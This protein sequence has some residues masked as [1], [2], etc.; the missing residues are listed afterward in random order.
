M[1]GKE[2]EG[3]TLRAGN[4]RRALESRIFGEQA[5]IYPM[6]AK[7]LVEWVE[8]SELEELVP[9]IIGSLSFS[10][11][12]VFGPE[13]GEVYDLDDKRT[14]TYLLNLF[15]TTEGATYRPDALYLGTAISNETEGRIRNADRSNR[16]PA[17][18]EKRRRK[19]L[20]RVGLDE[21]LAEEK[22]RIEKEE[23][24]KTL[25]RAA[26]FIEIKNLR[27]AR[28]IIDGAFIQRM[29]TCEDPGQG[30]ELLSRDRRFQPPITPDKGHWQSIFGSYEEAG[31]DTKEFGEKLDKTLRAIVEVALPGEGRDAPIFGERLV[32]GRKE[33]IKDERV[34]GIPAAVY[35]INFEKAEVF[36][37]W[38]KH[39]LEVSGGRLD[40]V[41]A[42]WRIALAWELP[43]YLGKAIKYK[44]RDI[45]DK[46]GEVTGKREVKTTVIALPSVGTAIGPW[47]MQLGDKQRIE[48]G[49]DADGNRRVASKNPSHTGYPLNFLGPQE[50]VKR[51]VGDHRRLE[52]TLANQP[53]ESVEK[54]RGLLKNPVALKKVLTE[55][56]R[57]RN[58]C[59]SF[60]HESK[61]DIPNPRNSQEKIR[62]SLWE[63]WRGN[64]GRK[65]EPMSLADPKF[66]WILTE[67]AR[68]SDVG[69][70]SPGSFGGWLLRRFRAFNVVKNIRSR[71]R[72]SEM[73]APEFFEDITRNW[74]KIFGVVLN[75]PKSEKNYLEPWQNPRSW[76]VAG[77]LYGHYSGRAKDTKLVGKGS[78]LDH[79]TPHTNEVWG[80]E[81]SGAESA[82]KVS[83]D[84][85]FRHARNA[86]F[87]RQE[88]E[89][90]IRE[91]L[92]IPLRK[93]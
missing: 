37:N 83:V 84:E 93:I 24:S 1:A 2:E 19:K 44:V 62:A 69:E 45:K 89:E 79:R 32:N 9:A 81:V 12:L 65:I 49:L 74:E 61:I 73:G 92:N 63:V 87:L 54:V 29:G 70:L 38:L 59:E 78:E 34:P 13:I 28:R 75:V 67:E 80:N 47:F 55:M 21:E 43:A 68:E 33:K 50:F 77:L 11:G 57:R 41:W 64:S 86:G 8:Y 5:G 4:E 6:S 42:A 15:T 18:W 52:K 7:D 14:L 58:P 51:L 10:E 85:I 90:W 76:W 23:L 39:Q 3:A 36:E 40:V 82:K 16:D 46:T 60:L 31:P 66:P 27:D 72:L 17:G 88:D 53:K 91:L 48:W 71:P 20:K 30:A 26:E 25:G 22:I 35:A 56:V